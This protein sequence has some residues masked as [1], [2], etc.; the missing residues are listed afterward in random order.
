MNKVEI[1]FRVCKV[2]DLLDLQAPVFVGSDVCYE[3]RFA[4]HLDPD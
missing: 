3:D 1:G 4:A 2:F